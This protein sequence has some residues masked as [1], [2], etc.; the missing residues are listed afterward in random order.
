MGL[1]ALGLFIDESI[2]SRSTE[3]IGF[4]VGPPRIEV[5]G[6]KETWVADVDVGG[7]EELLISIP[8]SPYSQQLR[9]ADEGT[10]IKLARNTAGLWQIIG[11][12]FEKVGNTSVATLN[13][14]TEGFLYT[15]GLILDT[16]GSPQT[17][18]R[19]SFTPPATG[20]SVSGWTHSTLPYGSISPYGTVIYGAIQSV[21]LGNPNPAP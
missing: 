21:K 7:G 4:V 17:Q 8:I 14:A 10:P 20:T 12:A 15:Y 3:K 16:L 9:H 6:G 18:Q 13:I 19:N 11:R 5:V 1:R 2:D